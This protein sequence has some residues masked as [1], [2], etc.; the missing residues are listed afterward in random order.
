MSVDTS[1]ALRVT[2]TIK[3]DLQ[4]VWDAWT[5][6][7]HLKKWACPAPHG[8]ESVTCDFR[9]GGSYVLSMRVEGKAYTAFGT[10]REIE[11]P[12]RLVYT[13]D[14]KEEENRMGETLVTVEFRRIGDS[15][16]VALLHEGFAAVEAKDGHAE[17]WVACLGH[18]A[19]LFD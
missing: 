18:F 8:V 4:R 19:A 12:N 15:T 16:E 17:G 5:Q 2:R 11:E 13:W 9:V 1:R 6:P 10:Y 14:W 3:A 7:E